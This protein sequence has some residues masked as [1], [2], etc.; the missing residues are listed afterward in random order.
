MRRGGPE[1]ATSNAIFVPS[2][3]V[4]NCAFGAG[5]CGC[6]ESGAGFCVPGAGFCVA[7]AGFCV[8]AAG[9][10]VAGARFS[11]PGAGSAAVSGFEVDAGGLDCGFDVALAQAAIPTN[12][13]ATPDNLNMRTRSSNTGLSTAATAKN[14]SATRPIVAG[15]PVPLKLRRTTAALAKV[16]QAARAESGFR[17]VLRSSF[18]VLRS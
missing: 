14:S 11:V 15:L 8:A 5:V 17:T 3:E 13:S 7:A 2:G 18:L 6:P 4:A 9:F 10:C 12:N 1:P 16:I